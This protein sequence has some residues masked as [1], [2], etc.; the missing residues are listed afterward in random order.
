MDAGLNIIE[1]VRINLGDYMTDVKNN[2]DSNN[3]DYK[4]H[5]SGVDKNGTNS[6]IMYMEKHGVEL[7]INNDEI[8]YIKSNNNNLNYVME[9]TEDTNAIFTLKEIK[10]KI[11]KEFNVSVN[12]IRVDEFDGSDIRA[13]LTIKGDNGKQVKISL[14]RGIKNRVYMNTIKLI[15]KTT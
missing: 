10:N 2:L 9:L 15:N 3:I 7:S 5:D 11:A 8:V 14:N 13:S 4:I 1:G 6:T 12:R